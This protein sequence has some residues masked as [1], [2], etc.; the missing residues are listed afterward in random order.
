MLDQIIDSLVPYTET[1]F[2]TEIVAA[3]HVGPDAIEVIA[4]DSRV[5]INCSDA[6]IEI[7]FGES[8]AAVLK[9]ITASQAVRFIIQALGRKDFDIPETITASF[10]KTAYPLK[11]ADAVLAPVGI[12]Q[13]SKGPAAVYKDTQDRY[14]VHQDECRISLMLYKELYDRNSEGELLS[15][16]KLF[17]SD[18]APVLMSKATMVSEAL[19]AKSVADMNL[20]PLY[21]AAAVGIPVRLTSAVIPMNGVC[22]VGKD[23]YQA[24]DIAKALVPLTEAWESALKGEAVKQDRV[25][26]FSSA[27]IKLV[28]SSETRAELAIVFEAGWPTSSDQSNGRFIE[29]R[30][31]ILPKGPALLLLEKFGDDCR[32]GDPAILSEVVE[33]TK[34]IEP[35]V[36]SSASPYKTVRVKETVLASVAE[37]GTKGLLLTSSVGNEAFKDFSV[38]TGTPDWLSVCSS[39]STFTIRQ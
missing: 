8:R 32:T 27:E 18:H 17:C 22:K 11:M 28:R 19:A 1:G 24:S 31:I 2:I 34:D 35:I 25:A 12:T 29:E 3:E 9:G 30:R 39:F 10:Q 26:T 15:M 13:T 21:Q 4:G 23:I 20:V 14:Y 6:A 5:T 37:D 38:R 16:P 36:E 33:M 7:A